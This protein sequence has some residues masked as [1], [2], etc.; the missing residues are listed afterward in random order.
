M[1]ETI[2][3]FLNFVD[4]QKKLTDQYKE[5]KYS[6]IEK[7]QNQINAREDKYK[8]DVQLNA[9]F[10]DVDQ[11]IDIVDTSFKTYENK[12]SDNE[13]A[14]NIEDKLLFKV[15]QDRLEFSMVLN[16]GS[17]QYERTKIIDFYGPKVEAL[18]TSL[19]K[20]IEE[21]DDLPF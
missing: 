20:K 14:I 13:I 12:F 17:N 10:I 18:Y 2:D 1:G 11:L 4:E 7:I 6:E 8:K 15:Y 19:K 5:N 9:R 16:S 21:M 3:N